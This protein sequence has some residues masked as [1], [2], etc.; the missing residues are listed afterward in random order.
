MKVITLWYFV[1][2]LSVSWKESS[3]LSV[4]NRLM[5]WWF[6]IEIAPYEQ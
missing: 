2:S 6:V 5:E 4:Y 1:A 3:K